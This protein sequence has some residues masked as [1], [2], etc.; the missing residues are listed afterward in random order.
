MSRVFGDIYN[1][2]QHSCTKNILNVFTFAIHHDKLNPVEL[3]VKLGLQR[4]RKRK[5][6]YYKDTDDVSY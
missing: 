3:I 5:T 1:A 2:A 4:L 6:I